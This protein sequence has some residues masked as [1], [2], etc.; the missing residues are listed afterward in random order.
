MKKSWSKKTKKVKGQESSKQRAFSNRNGSIRKLS[1]EGEKKWVKMNKKSVKD[2]IE[3]GQI[4]I[5]AEEIIFGKVKSKR[6][7]WG[8]YLK[9]TYPSL[10][11]KTTQRYMQLAEN[12]DLEEHP[13][14]AYLGQAK[15]LKLI[16]LGDGKTPAEVLYD[17]EMDI[18][19]DPKDAD[20]R[21]QFQSETAALI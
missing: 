12:V 5:E 14:L 7:N 18:E 9:K 20:A 2:A 16:Q 10:Q 3:F 8:K 15:L 1:Q 19:F 13:T 17:G 21:K 11:P 6:G 4:L